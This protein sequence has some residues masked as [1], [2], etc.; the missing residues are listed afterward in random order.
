[1]IYSGFVVTVV[2]VVIYRHVVA[3]RQFIVGYR[4]LQWFCCDL[5]WLL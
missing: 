5:K 4:D 3:M 2:F 1:M